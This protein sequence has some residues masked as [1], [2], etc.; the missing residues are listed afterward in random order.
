MK[1]LYLFSII[2]F[3]SC[4]EESLDIPPTSPPEEV[5]DERIIDT[6]LWEVVIDPETIR[7]QRLYTI[8]RI[9]KHEENVVFFVRGMEGFVSLNMHDGSIHW[10]NRGTLENSPIVSTPFKIGSKIYY[11]RT[12]SIVNLDLD[13]G[14]RDLKELW[15]IESEFQGA[16]LR[17]YNNTVYGKLSEFG[18]NPFFT[19]WIRVPFDRLESPIPWTRFARW[20]GTEDIKRGIGPPFFYKTTK[21]I[22]L[23]VFGASRFDTGGPA[24]YTILDHTITA[25][26]LNADTVAWVRTFEED[27]GGTN[28]S[29]VLDEERFYSPYRLGLKCLDVENNALLWSLDETQLGLDLATGAGLHIYEDKLLAFGGLNTIKAFNKYTGKELWRQDL[30]INDDDWFAQGSAENTVNYYNGRVYYMSSWGQ[31]VSLD[32][33][34]GSI[35]RYFLDKRPVIEEYDV[36]LFE[37]NFK[38]SAMTISE[39][40]IIYTSEGFRFLAFEVPDKDL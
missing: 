28:Q 3:F 20:D 19:E 4:G 27:L 34:D 14:Q 5:K 7:S 10:D 23:M 37:P 1:Y 18:N 12:S 6:F 21:G 24:T 31:L 33:N 2:V 38:F 25:Y 9:L 26:D 39:D 22:D 32:P 15:P 16:S 29:S 17:I 40:G 36:E 11:V 30:G 13:N 35:R 8:D